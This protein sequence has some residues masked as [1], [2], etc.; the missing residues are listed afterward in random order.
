MNLICGRS[1]AFVHFQRVLTRSDKVSLPIDR[2]LQG[3]I[4]NHRFLGNEKLLEGDFLSEIFEPPAPPPKTLHIVI[5]RP[6]SEWQQNGI[7][8]NNHV[9]TRQ[10]Y[11]N[12]TLTEV[13]L[14]MVSH[15]QLSQIVLY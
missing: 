1:A 13:S 9:V 14:L 6:G 7:G 5:R 3:S 12:L 4:K 15:D 11:Q 10:L 8:A 2:N